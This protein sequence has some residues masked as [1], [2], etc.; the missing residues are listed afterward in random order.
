MMRSAALALLLVVSPAGALT[1]QHD[2]GG[3]LGVYADRY[4]A[5]AARGERVRVDGVCNSACTL[6]LGYPY[7]CVTAR[8][9]FGLHAARYLGGPVSHEGNAYL[10]AT[11]PP[12]TRAWLAARG[13]LSAR[14]KYM[15]GAVS[16]LPRCR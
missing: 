2:Q 4:A 6:V 16:G 5:L 12:A 1:I 10:M 9:R 15:P 14:M 3:N 13:G 7:A 8:A 11:Y